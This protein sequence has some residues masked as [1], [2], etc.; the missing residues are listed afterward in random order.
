MAIL[1]VWSAPSCQSGAICFGALPGW[2]S[3]G[4]SEAQGTA[5]AF[6]VAVSR[7]VADAASVAEG[8]CLRVLSESRGEQWWF[9]NG[10]AD[11]DGDAGVVQIT[12]GSLKQLLAVRGFVRSG[13]TFQFAPGALTPA[14]LL[15][16]YVLTNL[17]DDS[18]S[19]LSL[20][21]SDYPLPI[22]VGA[23]DR[24]TRGGV[25]DLIEQQ[26]GYLVVLRAVYTGLALTS[27][28]LDVL[29]DPAAALPTVTL[30]AGAQVAGL[31]R[32]R[33]ALKA[34]TVAVP[35]DSTG[36]PM[37]QTV[38]VIDSTSGSAPA[39]IV[40]RD[41][42]VLS[43]YPIQEDDQF[44]GAYL[45]QSDGTTTI[46][47]DSRASDSAVQVAAIGSLAAGALVTIA[48]DTTG[49]PILEVT[50]P[51]GVAGSRGRLVA[52]VATSVTERRRNLAT[53]GTFETWTSATA[54]TGWTTGGDVSGGTPQIGRVPRALVNTFDGTTSVAYTGGV[55]YTTLSY[56]GSTPG[57]VL[58]S[59]EKVLVTSGG[60][61]FT[62]TVADSVGI[63]VVDG[64]GV[65]SFAVNSFTPAVTHAVGRPLSLD[66]TRKPS[67]YPDDGVTLTNAAHIWNTGTANPP[68]AAT[69]RIQSTPI[70]IIYDATLPYVRAAAGFSFRSSVPASSNTGAI[71]LLDTASGLYGTILS[72]AVSAGTVPSGG[73][74]HETLTASALLTATTT[75]GMAFYNLDPNN[76]SALVRWASLWI[77]AGTSGPAMGALYGSGSN[78]LFHR[79]QQ[80]LKGVGQG[81]RY[82]ATGVDLAHLFDGATPLALGQMV[83]LRSDRL[84]VDATVKIVKLDYRFDQTET[85][86]LELGTITPRLTGVTF[87]L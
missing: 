6:R 77:D 76:A 4:G 22:T 71:A 40:L 5:P 56:T 73:T 66:T 7:A 57:K 43:P 53:Y 52:S 1:Q 10:V 26:T 2:L 78:A 46:I 87:D 28:A 31:Q 25:V 27:F 21:T 80:V 79:A 69:R 70:T 74:L 81:T 61:D 64:T 85:L 41:T 68:V 35:F 72:T 23:L 54:A 8:R 45:V 84:G 17:A 37:G 33:D 42:N 47:A 67:S 39:W 20:G 75:V 15:N 9:I 86:N 65:G 50:S 32:T 82:T 58:L 18:L 38:W 36:Q 12:A 13:E 59:R 14:E 48:R 63:H 29:E 19:W 34:A 51:S 3:A 55:P 11:A 16:T 24:V 60:F 83:R 49:R 62:V 44:I 30:S